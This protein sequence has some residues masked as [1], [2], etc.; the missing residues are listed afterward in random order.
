[1]HWR[2][3]A[4]DHPLP[5]DQVHARLLRAAA[6]AGMVH[7]VHHLE[8]EFVLDVLVRSGTGAA[9]ATSTT[10]GERLR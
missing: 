1:V 9:Q 3:A 6:G 10:A 7:R 2:P 5:T 8:D 4:D